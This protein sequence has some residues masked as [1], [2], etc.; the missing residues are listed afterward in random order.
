MIA[1]GISIV[2][3]TAYAATTISTNI[4]TEGTLSVT[5]TSTLS[6][7]VDIGG[8]LSVTGKINGVKVYRA[9]LIQS[10]TN[11]PVA[12]VLENSLGQT[13]TWTYSDVGV[14]YATIPGGFPLGKTFLLSAGPDTT[15]SGTIQI[16]LLNDGSLQLVTT[17]EGG[18]INGLMQVNGA[19]IE[20]LVY[21]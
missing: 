3:A 2:F 5:G 17:E 14:Y 7:N 9:L 18:R 16:E 21:P 8:N 19:S 15:A 13:V 10:A 6:G 4:L 12:N 1:L 11:A 20:I